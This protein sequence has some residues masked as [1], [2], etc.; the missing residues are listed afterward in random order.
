MIQ[1]SCT[2]H[3]PEEILVAKTFHDRTLGRCGM[4]KTFRRW[5]QNRNV[6]PAVLERTD[7]VFDFNV[8]RATG[9]FLPSKE[10]EQIGVYDSL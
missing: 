10:E 5:K 3:T 8:R 1:R 2:S 7:P 4:S 9:C 6:S